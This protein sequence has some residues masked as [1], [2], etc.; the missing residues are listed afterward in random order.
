MC[1][2]AR[3]FILPWIRS[4]LPVVVVVVARQAEVEAVVAEVAVRQVVPQAALVVEAER[5]A[6]LQLPVQAHQVL[7]LPVLRAQ[8]RLR[9]F[10]PA[11]RLQQ[12]A[13][14]VDKAHPVQVAVAERVQVVV[15]VVVAERLPVGIVRGPQFPAWNSSICCLPQAS[16]RMRI[17]SHVARKSAPA[18]VSTI[19]CSVQEPRRCIVQR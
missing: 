18:V 3:H 17:S 6:Q 2:D 10:R 5:P 9:L 14:V 11:V 8:L 4:Q 15:A 12:V 19:P 16:I 13:E 7:A 1:T